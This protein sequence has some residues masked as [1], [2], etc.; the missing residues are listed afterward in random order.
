[1]PYTTIESAVS[2]AIPVK[3]VRGR[4]LTKLATIYGFQRRWWGLESDRSLKARMLADTLH[5]A[6][7]TTPEERRS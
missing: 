3:P 4:A 2:R 6:R 7:A 1:M 5:R